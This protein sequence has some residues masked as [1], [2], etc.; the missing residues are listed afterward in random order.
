MTALLPCFTKPLACAGAIILAWT[1]GVALAAPLLPLPNP[2]ETELASRLQPPGTPGHWLGTDLLGRDI[3]SR[4]IWGTRLSLAVA[5]AATALAAIAGSGIGLWAGFYGGKVDAWLMRSMD[6][7]MALPY[8]LL[9]LAIVA[10]LGPGLANALLAIAVVNIPFFARAVRGATVV[11]RHRPFVAASRVCGRKPIGVLLLHVLPN[12]FPVILIT[13]STTL[14]W[15]LLETAGLSFL[16]LG[17]RPPTADLGSMLGEGR[18]L[19]LIAPHLALLPGVVIFVVVAAINLLADGL[20]DLL[21]P[22]A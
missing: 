21:D 16:G 1:I 20:R 18:M 13:A 9:A 2:A 14:G 5:A 12:V 17:A 3:L 22:R 19:M 15:M 6:V 8:L 10:A 7:V 4:L 11:L